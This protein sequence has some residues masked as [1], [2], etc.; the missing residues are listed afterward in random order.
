MKKPIIDHSIP[1][2][3]QILQSVSKSELCKIVNVSEFIKYVTGEI[4]PIAKKMHEENNSPYLFVSKHLEYALKLSVN[5]GIHIGAGNKKTDVLFEN[6]ATHICCIDMCA[7]TFQEGIYLSGEKSS[8]QNLTNSSK[9]HKMFTEEKHTDAVNLYRDILYKDYINLQKE[10][11]IRNMYILFLL[12]ESG[13]LYLT[14]FIININLICKMESIGFTK[15]N[16][17]IELKHV[18]HPEHG[19]AKLYKSKARFEVRLTR[20]MITHENTIKLYG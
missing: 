11:N 20:S 5:K 16:A 8:G 19:F 10:Y 14:G 1:H 6:S 7:V 17:C 3:E 18:I 2:E 9:L 12:S 4:T 15:S 13:K